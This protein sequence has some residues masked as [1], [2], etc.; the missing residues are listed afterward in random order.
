[1]WCWR[2]DGPWK[3]INDVL[4]GDLRVLEGRNRQSSAG[5]LDSQSVKATD[6]GGGR[7]CDSAKKV[8]GRKR[9]IFLDT[10][11]WLL[12][13]V[14]TAAKVQGGW[15]VRRCAGDMGDV[16][17]TLSEGALGDRQTV[18]YRKRLHSFAQKVD[19]GA[20]VRLVGA[21]PAPEQGL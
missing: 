6:R 8:N 13:V 9:H 17:P 21:V 3:R 1:L 4:R 18:G 14:V 16:A 12:A 2:N 15:R 10:L 5:I 20:D 19:R 11:G 7:G